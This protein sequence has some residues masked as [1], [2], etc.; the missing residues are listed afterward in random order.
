[1]GSTK[2]RRFLEHSK[3]V[4]NCAPFADDVMGNDEVQQTIGTLRRMVEKVTECQQ[5]IGAPC[6]ECQG[7]WARQEAEAKID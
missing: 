7:C 2:L 1:M 6:G 5:A 3:K 4:Q